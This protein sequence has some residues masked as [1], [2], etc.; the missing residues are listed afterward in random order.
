MSGRRFLVAALVVSGC[1]GAEVGPGDQTSIQ[2]LQADPG[3]PAT[4]AF[5]IDNSVV[6]PSV[7]FG[8]SSSK[9]ETTAGSHQLAI[10][11][12]SGPI[13]TLQSDLHAGKRYYLVSARGSLVLTE[14]ASIDSSG[15]TIP[16]DT[17]QRRPDRAHLR[18]VNVPGSP[19]EAP[20]RVNLRLTSPTTV[21]STASFGL[22]TRIATYSSLIYLNPGAVTIQLTP[23]GLRTV[24]AETSFSV[25]AGEVKDLIVQRDASGAL[26]LRVVVE[27]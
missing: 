7:G 3:A 19:I 16:P 24:L 17:G 18:F 4:V 11:S 8:Q 27:R 25:A 9:V 2:L 12:L 1:A 21:D 13:A 20:Y 5:S 15:S 22:D 23:E 14:I 6:D 26:L 10:E